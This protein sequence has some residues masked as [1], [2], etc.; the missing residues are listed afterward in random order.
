M[1]IRGSGQ[2]NGVS[3]ERVYFVLRLSDYLV[4]IGSGAKET[5][6][7]IDFRY[8]AAAFERGNVMMNRNWLL[9]LRY[10]GAGLLFAI[11]PGARL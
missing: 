1:R 10:V 9:S 4:V 5:D 6:C 8:D 7:I 3:P 11:Q 2:K